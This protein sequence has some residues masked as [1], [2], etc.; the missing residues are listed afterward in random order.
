MTRGTISTAMMK[1]HFILLLVF[2]GTNWAIW[3]LDQT[4]LSR[5]AIA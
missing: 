2:S 3:L 5:I 1:A 4:R